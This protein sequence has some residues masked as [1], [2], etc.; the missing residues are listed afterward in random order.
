MQ[1]N[2]RDELDLKRTMEGNSSAAHIASGAPMSPYAIV[3]L[4]AA[5]EDQ[6]KKRVD[7]QVGVMIAI[8]EPDMEEDSDEDLAAGKRTPEDAAQDPYVSNCSSFIHACWDL[9][10]F[11]E[12]RFY[13]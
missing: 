6:Q 3:N 7:H 4:T 1:D 11:L 10:N 12:T 2:L 8:P 9:C 5:S 13:V